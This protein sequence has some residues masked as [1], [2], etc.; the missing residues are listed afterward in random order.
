L[1]GIYPRTPLK[2]EGIWI[3]MA[4]RFMVTATI[5][6][7]YY[8]TGKRKNASSNIHALKEPMQTAARKF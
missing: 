8:L 4:A 6:C 1:S 3:A 7:L 2:E 5:G